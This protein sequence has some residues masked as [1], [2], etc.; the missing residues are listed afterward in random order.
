LLTGSAFETDGAFDAAVL[1]DV[2]LLIRGF[3]SAYRTI[4]DT[5]LA[6]NTFLFINFHVFLFLKYFR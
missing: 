1:V 6:S 4:D 3:Y 5:G 2:D